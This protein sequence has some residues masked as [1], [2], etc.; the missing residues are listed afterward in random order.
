MQGCSVHPKAESNVYDISGEI[1]DVIVTVHSLSESLMGASLPE[2]EKQCGLDMAAASALQGGAELLHEVAHGVN[3][4]FIQ[5]RHILECK[6]FNPIYTTFVHDGEP[7][8]TFL[9]FYCFIFI[10]LLWL[11][12]CIF[13]FNLLGAAVCVEAVGGLTWL[14]TTSFSLAMFSMMMITFRAALYPVKRSPDQA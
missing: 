3:K 6:S 5:I 11:L 2:L 13:I 7:S 1:R 4:D 14:Y 8:A 9:F 12:A 10:H